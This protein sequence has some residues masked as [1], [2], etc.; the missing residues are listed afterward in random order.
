[1]PFYEISWEPG[2][3]SVAFYEDEAEMQ[4]ALYE[5]NRRAKAGLP[6][7]PVG[8][9]AERVAAVRE[10]D[11]HPNDYNEADT[12]SADV[13]LA[14]VTDLIKSAAKD[15]D[16]VIPLGELAVE[17]RKLTHPMVDE[18]AS[19]HDSM[20][21]MEEVGQPD[22]TFLDADTAPAPPEDDIDAGKSTSGPKG[23]K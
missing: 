19:P 23:D 4:R 16:G 17:V 2:T 12:L 9:P 14:E 15:N 7:G 1:M 5:H 18:K 11:K 21:K 10:Y 22:L 6:G 3:T 20:F 13:A 8:A